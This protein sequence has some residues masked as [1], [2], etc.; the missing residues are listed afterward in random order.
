[1]ETETK[2]PQDR[3][4]SFSPEPCQ[5]QTWV[6]SHTQWSEDPTRIDPHLPRSHT[7]SHTDLQRA[8]HSNS[9]E[10][11]DQEQLTDK[12][13]RYKLGSQGR[14]PTYFFYCPML[15]SSWVLRPDLPTWVWWILSWTRLCGSSP[16]LSNQPLHPGSLFS[17]TL[18]H[19][20]SVG[21]RRQTSSSRR[22]VTT[23][24]GQSTRISM[25]ILTNV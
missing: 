6:V 15:L 7:G 23:V 25:N 20:P 12:A 1:M 22:S 16:E 13:G 3:M 5:G 4:F 10:A 24:T 14:G 17:P 18:P 9:H 21:K 8:H 11:E 19:H 2:R